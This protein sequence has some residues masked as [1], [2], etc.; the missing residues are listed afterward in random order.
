[1]TQRA[2]LAAVVSILVAAAGCQKEPSVGVAAGGSAVDYP[3]DTTAIIGFARKGPAPSADQLK[4]AMKALLREEADK[5]IAELID[6]CIAPVSAHLERATVM[7]RG[8]LK[9]ERVVATAS[10]P[11]LRPAL[12][13]CLKAMSDKRGK[14]FQPAEDGAYTMY[15]LGSDPMVARWTGADQVMVAAKKEE[16][17]SAAAAAGG[18]KGTPLEKV[19]GAVDRS[20]TFWIAAAG[21]GMPE[22]AQLES[23]SGSIQDLTG[24][25]KAVFK[26]PEAASQA[27][28]MVQMMIP[29]GVKLSG[30]E[31]SIGLNVADLPAIMISGKPGT[32]PTPPL[33]KEHARALLAAGP[34]VFAFLLVAGDSVEAAPPTAVEPAAPVP[35]VVPPAPEAAP[36][37]PEPVSPTPTAKPA[38][39]LTP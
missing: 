23:V 8:G 21:P 20:G 16:I 30:A 9:D 17:E 10:G 11:G 22:Q 28:G 12:E 5:E 1:M 6:V 32:P 13:A 36:P 27:S 38:A 3:A 31:L 25:V 14:S 18:L 26:N 15:P 33:S 34:L 39:P 29:K 24:S 37:T 2:K 19:V 7:V 4:E 35:E